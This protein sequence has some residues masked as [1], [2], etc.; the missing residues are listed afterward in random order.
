MLKIQ[1]KQSAGKKFYRPK[2]S[3]NNIIAVVLSD[4]LL[5]RIGLVSEL[6]CLGLDR[7][8]RHFLN[9]FFAPPRFVI[10]Y[11]IRTETVCRWENIFEK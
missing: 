10:L 2:K 8:D 11:F 4:R 6:K 5:D 3:F 1:E 9:F 7:D